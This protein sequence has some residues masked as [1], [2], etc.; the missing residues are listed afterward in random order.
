[1]IAICPKGMGASVRAL[2]L[3]GTE[4]NGVGIKRQLYRRT[5][6]QRPTRRA[7]SGLIGLH[8]RLGDDERAAFAEVYAERSSSW[9]FVEITQEFYDEVA[10]GNAI[11]SVTLAGNGLARFPMGVA[12]MVDNC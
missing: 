4:E 3:Q 9:R 8:R 11:R 12:Y 7:R 5:G 2:Y 1:M 10:S 6:R